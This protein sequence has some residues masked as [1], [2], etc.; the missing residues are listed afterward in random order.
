MK[1]THHSLTMV[2][3]ADLLKF[4][5][6]S[7]RQ[8]AIPKL[9]EMFGLM[10]SPSQVRSMERW[11][12]MADEI[13]D[14]VM[15]EGLEKVLMEIWKS[16]PTSFQ[17]FAYC[18]SM[19]ELEDGDTCV[20]KY[21]GYCWDCDPFLPWYGVIANLSWAD[22]QFN[23]DCGVFS[24]DFLKEGPGKKIT[25]EQDWDDQ[26]YPSAIEMAK[27][28]GEG[29]TKATGGQA[30]QSLC[31]AIHMLQDLGVP[32]HV[33]CTVG[34]DHPGFEDEMLGFWRRLYSD[35]SESNK[36][37]I[38]GKQIGPQ[39]EALLNNE[40]Q[41]VDTFENLGEKL[42]NMT[43]K[44]LPSNDNVPSPNKVEARRMT[45]Q[46]IACTIKALSLFYG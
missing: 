17:H 15:E 18:G 25:G 14:L 5:K 43:R 32:H 22:I 27:F 26:A 38:L 37:K 42:V 34:F 6:E 45:T 19:G 30:I 29:A 36:K 31:F 9:D 21:D 10:G 13:D 7:G 33:L 12:A 24:Q 2:A 16:K 3:T 1:K 11:V 20:K 46:G 35:R 4:W 39:V 28:Y 41:C 8:P 44:R 40:L 23:P